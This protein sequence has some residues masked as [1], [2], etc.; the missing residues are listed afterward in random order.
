MIAPVVKF[1][2]SS[3]N[4]DLKDRIDRSKRTAVQIVNQTALDVAFRSMKACPV[5][6]SAPIRELKKTFVKAV[7]FKKG[8]YVIGFESTKV[9]EVIVGRYSNKHRQSV[10]G[11]D[12]EGLP[13]A[14]NRIITWRTLGRNFLKSRFVKSI[15]AL[16]RAV[17]RAKNV[18]AVG[19]SLNDQYG[20]GTAARD[21]V[22][23]KAKA[24][25][26]ASYD[27]NVRKGVVKITAGSRAILDKA[28]QDGLLAVQNGWRA[29]ANRKLQAALNKTN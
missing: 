25:I 16:G 11:F 28:A 27:Y 20:Y 13:D 12:F 10:S 18:G 4:A 1:N 17:G 29:Y 26:F 6:E 24:I 22:M 23:T 8:K 21:E 9:R 3:F 15:G 14:M 5:A 19:K 2:L 7:V